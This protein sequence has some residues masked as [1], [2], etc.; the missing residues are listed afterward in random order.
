MA[1]GAA[2]ARVAGT[3]SGKPAGAKSDSDW[4]NTMFNSMNKR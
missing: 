4:W 3:G 2:P 1:S